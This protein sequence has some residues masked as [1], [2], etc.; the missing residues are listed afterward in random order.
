MREFGSGSR[1][2][3]ENAL[4]EAGIK[5]KELNTRMELDST[6][7]LLS[8]VEAGLGVTFVSRWAVR[9]QLALGT[10]KLARVRGLKLSR[11][12]S[13]AYPAGPE[14]AGNAGVFR[15]F[16]LARSMELMPR[17]TGK[18]TTSLHSVVESTEKDLNRLP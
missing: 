16:L 11:M 4:A 9:N 6:E 17:A 14:P 8:A 12:F 3:V 1:R 18:A 5:K 13:I 10:L 7:G 2:V 15:K